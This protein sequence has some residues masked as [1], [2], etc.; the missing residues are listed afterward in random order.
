MG[1][2]LTGGRLARSFTKCLLVG[3]PYLPSTMFLVLIFVASDAVLEVQH[4]HPLLGYLPFYHSDMQ[5]MYKKIVSDPL[6]PLPLL[7]NKASP[8]VLDVI[9]RCRHFAFLPPILLLTSWN[10][11]TNR[12]YELSMESVFTLLALCLFILH[13][14][15]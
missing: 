3:A 9:D 10:F 15:I 8:A 11:R 2:R 12:S 7:A 6:N 13:H 5:T 4:A 1:S 14:F